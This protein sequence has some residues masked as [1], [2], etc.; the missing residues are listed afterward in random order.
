MKLKS[1]IGSYWPFLIAGVAVLAYTVARAFLLSFTYDESLSYLAI[2]L[3]NFKMTSMTHT[4]NHTVM[5]IESNRLVHF[6]AANNHYLNSAG[7]YL[8]SLI[9]GDSE[10]SLRLPN[11]LAHVLYLVTCFQLVRH[12]NS[13]IFAFLSFT[14]LVTNPFLLEFFGLARGYGMAIA[15]MMLSLLYLKN[16]IG[17]TLPG[18]LACMLAAMLSA[19]SNMAFF[20]FYF[21]LLIVVFAIIVHQNKKYTWNELKLLF[22]KHQSFFYLNLIFLMF[23]LPVLFFLN[24]TGQ[25][26]YGSDS[27]FNGMIGS[28]IRAGFFLDHNPSLPV[29]IAAFLLVCLPVGYFLLKF[30]RNK[31]VTFGLALAL[32]LILATMLVL[33]QHF[34]LNTPLP[35]ERT[36]L[37]FFPLVALILVL[38]LENLLR[39]QKTRMFAWSMTVLLTVISLANFAINANFSSSFTWK[40]DQHTRE[41]FQKI[42]EKAGDREQIN[43]CSGKEFEP[44]LNFYR[45]SRKVQ[46][47]N[48]VSVKGEIDPGCDYFYFSAEKTGELKTM[49]GRLIAYPDTRSVLL[50]SE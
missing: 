3:F 32:I 25:L 49:N 38:S 18:P 22:L 33:L 46:N 26:F 24:Y 13:R 6:F 29:I 35:K 28:M 48:P 47:M 21:V 20:N 10:L 34:L 14:F 7:M 4:E 45:V 23:A 31:N 2:K 1:A 43:V 30:F 16:W 40:R 19:L 50:L 42:C 39:V 8:C 17:S 5:V 36:A 9:F 15:F 27:F 11:L 41:V 37:Y 12:F 44:T